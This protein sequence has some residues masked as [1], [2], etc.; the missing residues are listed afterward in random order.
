M[1]KTKK[2]VIVAMVAVLG[3]AGAISF[4]NRAQASIVT[5][6]TGYTGY[7]GYANYS[8]YS[9]YQGYQGYQG[10]PSYAGY[11]GYTGYTGYASYT[12]LSA[13]NYSGGA[14]YGFDYSNYGYCNNGAYPGFGNCRQSYCGDGK[15][16]DGETRYSCS[17][18][19]KPSC[20]DECDEGSRKCSGNGYKICRDDDDDGC[21]EWGSVK[22]CGSGKECDDGYCVAKKEECYCG[23]GKCNGGETKS[24]CPE[25][26]GSTCDSQCSSGAYECSGTSSKTCGFF[27]NSSC[28]SWGNW[29]SCDSRCYFCGDGNCDSSCGESK[30]NCSRDCGSTCANQCSSGDKRCAGSVAREVCRDYN[31]DGCNEWGGLVKCVGS[32][33]CA[34]GE[35]V[36]ECQ[37]KT[38]SYYGYECGSASDG[39]GNTLNCG[40]CAGG[41]TCSNHKCVSSCQPKTCSYYGYQCGTVDDGCGNTL[42]C[43]TCANNQTCTNNKCVDKPTCDNPAN[44][45]KIFVTSGTYSFRDN[46][47][48]SGCGYPI[49]TNLDET[50]ADG[51]CSKTAADSGLKGNYKAL[52]YL[53]KRDPM[54][55]LPAGK[56][57]WNME[58]TGSNQCSWHLVAQNPVDFFTDEGGDSYLRNPIRFTEQGYALDNVGVWTGIKPQGEGDY[59]LLEKSTGTYK[60]TAPAANYVCYGGQ[61]VDG[62]ATQYCFG[63][64]N[65]GGHVLSC[66]EATAWYGNTSSKGQKWSYSLWYKQN[67]DARNVCERTTRAFYCVEQ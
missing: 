33:I 17:R 51:I 37:P 54:K 57:F 25:D 7:T 49:S 15:C 60:C 16:N 3:L 5:G 41:Q 65:D 23:D 48:F 2:I 63:F 18:D 12:N 50:W 14:R 28:R 59:S 9:G 30:Y 47:D 45:K 11:L 46:A 44:G 35:C 58:K 21:S 42:N 10:Y 64:K 43:G 19:C 67:S 22:K 66:E 4:A 8:G 27:G 36:N 62:C 38:C 26:C 6:N 20:K 40:N 1:I 29:K 56:T 55:V 32:Q 13:A 61:M 31:N 39:C 34:G 24:S 52:I 53:G